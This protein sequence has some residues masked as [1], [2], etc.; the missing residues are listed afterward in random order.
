MNCTISRQDLLQLQ[1][2]LLL[3]AM[4]AFDL[5]HIQ[6]IVDELHQSL[7]LALGTFQ[8][9]PLLVGER[10]GQAVADHR[11]LLFDAG[12]RVNAVRGTPVARRWISSRPVP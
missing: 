1:R 6:K 12:Q 2:H 9:F 5:G 3:Q 7:D 10:S 4:A 8:Q 11:L